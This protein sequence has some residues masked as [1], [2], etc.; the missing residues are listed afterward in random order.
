QLAGVAKL[1]PTGDRNHRKIASGPSCQVRGIVGHHLRAFCLQMVKF[2]THWAN[3]PAMF[4]L[5]PEG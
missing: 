5:S 2:K 4:D 1:I 3:C